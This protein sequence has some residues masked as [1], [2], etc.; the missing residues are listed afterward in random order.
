M[1]RI[2][3]ERAALDGQVFIIQF[4]PGD[5]AVVGLGVPL[6]PKVYNHGGPPLEFLKMI[7]AVI[8]A[9]TLTFAIGTQGAGAAG[10]AWLA[11]GK[12]ALDLFGS[13]VIAAT[14]RAGRI[15]GSIREAK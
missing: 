9:G 15:D 7:D 13:G 4:D 1:K 3:L 8:F 6:R 14:L 11:R 10:A 12:F 2:D 5:G